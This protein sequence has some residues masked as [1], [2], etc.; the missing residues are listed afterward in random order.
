MSSE[1]THTG[2]NGRIG[3][4]TASRLLDESGLWRLKQL[5]SCHGWGFNATVPRVSAQVLHSFLSGAEDIQAGREM[6]GGKKVR[7]VN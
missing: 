5:S 7:L 4:K 3:N 6:M 2:T 1:R